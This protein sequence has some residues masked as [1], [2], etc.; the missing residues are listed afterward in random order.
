MAAPLQS[1]KSTVN[2]AAGGTRVSKIRR[3]PPLKVK[4]ATIADRD[5]R[6]QRVVVIGV[7]A[8]TLAIVIIILFVGSWWGWSPRHYTARF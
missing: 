1:A 8:F 3:D 2:L 5:E 4:Q 6:D 7:L